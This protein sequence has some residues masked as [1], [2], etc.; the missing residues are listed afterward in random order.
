[1]Q[2]LKRVEL[3]LAEPSSCCF[4]TLASIGIRT[5]D[6]VRRIVLEAPGMVGNSR[7]INS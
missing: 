7:S 3:T 6:L 5:I 4:G 1:M 2:L